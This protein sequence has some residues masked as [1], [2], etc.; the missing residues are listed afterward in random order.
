MKKIPCELT[1]GN[2]GD[3][4]AMV[5]L[6]DDGTLYIPK[7]SKYGTFQEGVIACKAMDPDDEKCIQKE[8][9]IENK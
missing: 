8:V 9:W 4:I 1:L 5:Q 2:G 6:G 3:V 7:F